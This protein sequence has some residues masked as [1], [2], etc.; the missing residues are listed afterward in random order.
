MV[1]E[2]KNAYKGLNLGI[3][4]VIWGGSEGEEIILEKSYV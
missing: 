2:G 3:W 1:Y 4:K